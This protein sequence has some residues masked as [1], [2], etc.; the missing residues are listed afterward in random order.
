[1]G[2]G[3]LSDVSAGKAISLHLIRALGV[4]DVAVHGKEMWPP[5][6][7]CSRIKDPSSNT[8]WCMQKF[9]DTSIEANDLREIS[10]GM[11]ADTRSISKLSL[12]VTHSESFPNGEYPEKDSLVQ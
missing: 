3:T 4:T 11:S 6:M 10:R 8:I 1:M 5:L 2:S 12:A 9:N 7:I